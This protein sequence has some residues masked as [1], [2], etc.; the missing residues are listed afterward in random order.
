VWY[1]RSPRVAKRFEDKSDC[2]GEE[3]D[4]GSGWKER[5]KNWG[6]TKG[7]RGEVTRRGLYIKSITPGGRGFP[8]REEISKNPWRGKRE[9]ESRGRGGLPNWKSETYH[10]GKTPKQDT[11]KKGPPARLKGESGWRNDVNWTAIGEGAGKVQ[12]KGRGV[13]RI[14]R[15]E[16]V[17]SKK[18]RRRV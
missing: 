6:D 2:H 10:L 9:K 18:E 7:Q 5:K 1:V 16:T 4:S 15:T 12:K 17:K 8:C 13:P 11:S 14:R 3:K